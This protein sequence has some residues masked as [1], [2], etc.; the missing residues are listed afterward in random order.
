MRTR[1]D[2]LVD[3]EFRTEGWHSSMK[4][5]AKRIAERAFRHGAEMGGMAAVRLCEQI[6]L[7]KAPP[8]FG[9]EV[10]PAPADE[11][12]CTNCGHTPHGTDQCKR[13]ASRSILPYC[14]DRRHLKRR[15]GPHSRRILR[16]YAMEPDRRSGTDR[17][18]P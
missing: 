7:E 9:Y 18:K 8:E 13:C 2:D 17:R 10:Q 4:F 14:I 11:K 3:E 15:T 6:R 16:G 5:A 1:L 12:A